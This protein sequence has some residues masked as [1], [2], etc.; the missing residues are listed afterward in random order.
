MK[1][2]GDVIVECLPNIQE[3]LNESRVGVGHPQVYMCESQEQF[4]EAV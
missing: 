4:Q 2:A 3:D 1:G